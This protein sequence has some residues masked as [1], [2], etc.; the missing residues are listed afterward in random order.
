MF[1][2]NIKAFEMY[3]KTHMLKIS[4]NTGQQVALAT[5]QC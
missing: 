1:S 2:L 4:S 5:C 3:A